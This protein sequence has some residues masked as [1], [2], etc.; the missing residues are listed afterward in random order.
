MNLEG[1]TFPGLYIRNLENQVSQLPLNTLHRDDYLIFI[2]QI[3]GESVLEIDF[4]KSIL[5]QN[6]ICCILP[7]SVHQLLSVNK[8]KGWL[9]AVNGD[10][11][12]E[13]FRSILSE[14]NAGS[15]IPIDPDLASQ[16]ERILLVICQQNHVKT[17][18]S[19]TVISH[20]VSA[21]AGILCSNTTVHIDANAT[22]RNSSIAAQF[23]SLLRKHYRRQKSPSWYAGQL[24]LSTSYL[25]EC[26]KSAT[27]ST[28]SN[29]IQKE[30]VLEGKRLLAFS[31]NS[32]K[33][34]AYDLGYNDPA[35]F[36]RLFLK[37]T[38]T[39]PAAF[40]NNYRK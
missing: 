3:S 17:Y 6:C 33:E 25:N 38:G 34:I 21:F 9:L 2:L 30:I 12:D 28:V 36:N 35:Y 5:F 26:I 31:K 37:L 10:Q 4:F 20:L 22:D 8:P 15:P 40:R 13:R 29:W 16:L 23:K 19:L 24:N 27:G 32:T 1:Q 18:K 11:I 39:R 14:G 7:G